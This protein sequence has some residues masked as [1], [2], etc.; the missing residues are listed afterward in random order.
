MERVFGIDWLVVSESGGDQ[1]RPWALS[2][3]PRRSRA[4]IGQS[5]VSWYEWTG[6]REATRREFGGE[7]SCSQPSRSLTVGCDEEAVRLLHLLAYGFGRRVDGWR[8]RL[9]GARGTGVWVLLADR[10]GAQRRSAVEHHAAGAL[11]VDVIDHL[12]DAPPDLLFRQ[13]SPARQGIELEGIVLDEGLG[14]DLLAAAASL[15]LEAAVTPEAFEGLAFGQGVD[16]LARR[17]ASHSRL[18]SPRSLRE[19]CPRSS[20]RCTAVRANPGS[21][22]RDSPS[23]RG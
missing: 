4:A 19:A 8:R 1:R 21:G 22:A 18:R 12:G 23:G 2:R 15:V 11:G 14:I 20:R 16:S 17:L 6:R 10:V 13:M 7:I 3:C 5:S 9:L